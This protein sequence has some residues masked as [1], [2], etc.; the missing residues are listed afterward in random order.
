M[1]KKRTPPKIQTKEELFKR[2]SFSAIDIRMTRRE[3][4]SGNFRC[5]EIRGAILAIGEKVK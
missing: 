2:R 5:K 4:E 1:E 3:E